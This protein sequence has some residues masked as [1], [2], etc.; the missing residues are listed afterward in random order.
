MVGDGEFCGEQGLTER[1]CLEVARALCG[2]L[3]VHSF[4]YWAW[5]GERW[6]L[7][8]YLSL[9]ACLR[10]GPLRPVCAP[11]CG[12]VWTLSV[13]SLAFDSNVRLHGP[14]TVGTGGRFEVFVEGVRLPVLLPDVDQITDSATYRGQHV[15]TRAPT[16]SQL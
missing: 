5:C 10:I 15:F 2:I 4:W 13:G 6:V 1:R 11:A 16:A 7:P 3:P 14:F 8:T 12:P 9:E